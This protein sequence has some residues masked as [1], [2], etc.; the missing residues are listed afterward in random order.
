MIERF[1]GFCLKVFLLLFPYHFKETT[2][3]KEYESYKL[4]G[5]QTLILRNP[6]I[7]IFRSCVFRELETSD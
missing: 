3:Q 5:T 4:V 2:F 7:E 6:R 1:P